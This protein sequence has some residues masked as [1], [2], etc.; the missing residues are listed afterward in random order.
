MVRQREEYQDKLRKQQQRKEKQEWLT[1]QRILLLEL[2][3]EMVKQNMG[4]QQKAKLPKGV[5][6][7]L[8]W[9]TFT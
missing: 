5:Q 9:N 4:E 3:E 2:Q 7:R 6:N 8:I 1:R